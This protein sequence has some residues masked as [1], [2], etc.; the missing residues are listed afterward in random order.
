[1]FLGI[2]EPLN[3]RNETW[4]YRWWW[5]PSANAPT[6][7]WHEVGTAIPPYVFPPGEIPLHAENGSAWATGSTAGVM[8]YDKD[9]GMK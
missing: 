4:H 7:V 8:V 6:P 9:K 2:W 5:L 1:M 3:K